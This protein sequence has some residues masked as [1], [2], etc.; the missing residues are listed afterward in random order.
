VKAETGC[1]G[2]EPA[3]DIDSGLPEQGTV[4]EHVVTIIETWQNLEALK[5][6]LKTPH[7]SSFFETVSAY[8]ENVNIQVMAPA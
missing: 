7:M 4:R 1:L 6:H 2:Y 5:A 8:I 3:V